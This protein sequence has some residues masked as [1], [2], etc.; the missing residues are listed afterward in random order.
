M[1]GD[2]VNYFINC[3]VPV[4]SS[5]HLSF[6]SETRLRLCIL[7]FLVCLSYTGM[8]KSFSWMTQSFSTSVVSG[9]NWTPWAT[10][11]TPCAPVLKWSQVSD[12]G[13]G[14]SLIISNQFPILRW[15]YLQP[16]CYIFWKNVFLFFCC[17]KDFAWSCNVLQ[18][19]HKKMTS[20][21]K[22]RK[23]PLTG[24]RSASHQL[25]DIFPSVWLTRL[26]HT[27]LKKGP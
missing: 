6:H 26:H 10:S 12:L 23:P 19:Q 1:N 17:T 3:I 9:R 4:L 24:S 25:S 27:G 21:E 8:S 13:F 22:T 16:K 14:G 11:W 5:S 15:P 2:G 7:R 18:R 20:M